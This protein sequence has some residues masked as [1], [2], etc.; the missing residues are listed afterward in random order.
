MAPPAGRVGF[1]GLGIMGSRMAAQ[2][3]KGGADVMVWNRSK[4]KA[5]ELVSA[6]EALRSFRCPD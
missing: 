5:D 3:V 1:L 2:L 4:G 6:G